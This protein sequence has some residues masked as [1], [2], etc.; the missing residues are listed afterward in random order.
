MYM[1]IIRKSTIN[2]KRKSAIH[3]LNCQLIM[4][5]VKISRKYTNKYAI[6]T[7]QHC[8]YSKIQTKVVFIQI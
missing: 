5:Q 4:I 7:Q 2:K 1:Y 8:I 3:Q 6:R